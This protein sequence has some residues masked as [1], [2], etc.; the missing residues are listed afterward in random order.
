[1]IR[2]RTTI[3]PFSVGATFSVSQTLLAMIARF[4]AAK[5]RVFEEIDYKVA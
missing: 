1:M 2:P 3:R 5:M 4:A